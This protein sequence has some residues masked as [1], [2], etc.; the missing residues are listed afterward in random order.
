MLLLNLK[1]SCQRDIIYK[2]RQVKRMIKL[3]KSS[4][5]NCDTFSQNECQSFKQMKMVSRKF[6]VPNWEIGWR[7]QMSVNL[8]IKFFTKLIHLRGN[9]LLYFANSKP[10]WLFFFNKLSNAVCFYWCIWCV[11]N[12][13]IFG[14]TQN[15]KLFSMWIF[16]LPDNF[17]Y[18]NFSTKFY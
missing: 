7:E 9:R 1:Y 17:N 15:S 11:Y 16:W 12:Y 2:N 8:S 5:S 3:C 6:L 13:Q 14:L 18:S 10:L 4:S